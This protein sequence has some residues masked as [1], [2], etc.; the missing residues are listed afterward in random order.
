MNGVPLLDNPKGQCLLLAY[1]DL[2]GVVSPRFWA[3][4]L[5]L[6][7]ATP[8]TT[9]RA[10]HFPALVLVSP[11]ASG[12]FAAYFS[13][14]IFQGDSEG[15]TVALGADDKLFIQSAPS[16]RCCTSRTSTSSDSARLAAQSAWTMRCSLRVR[17]E[18]CT[19]SCRL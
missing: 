17:P 5:Y 2:L 15:S 9:N 1:D 7:A 13:D 12:D 14:I 8:P 6:R 18:Q 16:L 4:N 11:A 10:T 19:T 3:H